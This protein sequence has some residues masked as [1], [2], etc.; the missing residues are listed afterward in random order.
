M[1]KLLQYGVELTRIAIE[2]W[3]Q[4]QQR[5]S[6]EDDDNN[7]NTS[8]SEVQAKYVVA[9]SGC[10]GAA[11]ANGEEY[12]GNYPG[13]TV[14]LLKEFHRKKAKALWDTNPDGLAIETIPTVDE[15]RA[16]CEMLRELQEQE[17]KQNEESEAS[18][19]VSCAA[20]NDG[21]GC[22]CWISLACKNETE[23]NNGQLLEE[24]L[25]VIHE[26]DPDVRFIHAIGLN[27][28]DSTYIPSL[29]QILTSTMA[30]Q[31]IANVSNEHACANRRRGIVFYPN[32]GEE[33][34]AREGAWK[35]NTGC[36]SSED[37]AVRLVEAVDVVE[38]T[39]KE[40]YA[41]AVDDPSAVPSRP[42]LVLGGCC[43][44]TPDTIQLLRKM[45]Y[46]RRQ[47]QQQRH[48]DR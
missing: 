16:V 15:C 13:M 1:T 24:A 23:L 10:Y 33:W 31:Q 28:C 6:R 11:L 30:S 5:V 37:F 8:Q 40:S 38:T 21:S 3:Q 19:I 29:L 35:S 32:S 41:R 14:K 4:Q 39:W 44:T 26:A 12:T 9:S 36:T 34:D 17:L 42:R 20:G 7:D 43:R 27:C 45:V 46:A 18:N 47:A 22:C 25:L 48:P 2:R